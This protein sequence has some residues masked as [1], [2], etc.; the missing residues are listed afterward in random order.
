MQGQRLFANA[1]SNRRDAKTA[2]KRDEMNLAERKWRF[3]GVVERLVIIETFP[4]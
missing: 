1:N 2:E 3:Q 4:R